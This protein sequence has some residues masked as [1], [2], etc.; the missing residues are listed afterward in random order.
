[1]FECIG[2]HQ[3]KPPSEYYPST[4]AKRGH[5]GRCHSCW[6]IYG[7]A[8]R[9]K[10]VEANRIYRANYR[11]THR[12]ERARTTWRSSLKTRY[13][14]TPEQY[15]A[16]LAQ[17]DGKCALCGNPPTG[18]RRLCVDHS[19]KN[20]RVRALLCDPCNAGLGAFRDDPKLLTKAAAFVSAYLACRP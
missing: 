7:R 20:G 3:V 19:H 5:Q 17:Q 13:G 4:S 16:L 12:D 2:C 15:D 11:R 9:A 6:A 8:H 18:R 10:N 1:M 14:I